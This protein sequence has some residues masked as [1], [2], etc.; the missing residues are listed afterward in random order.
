[1]DRI[2]LRADPH[3]PGSCIRVEDPVTLASFVMQGMPGWDAAAI[4]QTMAAAHSRTVSLAQPV[5]VPI[6]CGTALV[7]EGRMHFF[8]DLYGHDRTLEAALRR[9]SG[10]GPSR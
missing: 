6:A 4:R 2:D 10:A 7:K 1:M 3:A 9:V 5:P 8:D